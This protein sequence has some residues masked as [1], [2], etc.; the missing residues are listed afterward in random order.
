MHTTQVEDAYNTGRGW[1]E[2]KT[3]QEEAGKTMLSEDHIA[4]FHHGFVGGERL[5]RAVR[6]HPASPRWSVPCLYR[7]PPSRPPSHV[8]VTLE[9][10]STRAIGT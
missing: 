3:D 9:C 6:T 4:S 10:A 5:R 1:G 8:L 7:L 2:A